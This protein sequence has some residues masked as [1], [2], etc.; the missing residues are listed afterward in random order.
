MLAA[1]VL[2][3]SVR[4]AS[5]SRGMFSSVNISRAAAS[6]SRSVLRSRCSRARKAHSRI[7]VSQTRS[8]LPSSEAERF[9]FLEQLKSL[10]QPAPGFAGSRAWIAVAPPQ[11][12]FLIAQLEAKPALP[13]RFPRCCPA[14]AEPGA[15]QAMPWRRQYAP[16]GW[17]GL[18]PKLELPR[19]LGRDLGNRTLAAQLK[20]D[21]VDN[22]PVQLTC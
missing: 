18:K 5:R 1:V 4:T 12:L 13:R 2:S 16:S 6:F 3:S 7:A 11:H 20:H 15:R 14:P 19:Q 10:L 9:L 22:A 8:G 17:P 21:R